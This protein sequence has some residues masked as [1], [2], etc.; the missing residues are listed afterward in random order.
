MKNILWQL[1]ESAEL[2]IL[3]FCLLTRTEDEY[4]SQ[5]HLHKPKKPFW[6]NTEAKEIP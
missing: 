6:I 3:H 5:L 2:Q 4:S 1:H